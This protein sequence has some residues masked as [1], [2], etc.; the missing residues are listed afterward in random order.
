MTSK[1]ATVEPIAVN[2]AKSDCVKS[3]PKIVVTGSIS[4]AN[5][6]GMNANTAIQIKQ[7]VISLFI[8]SP[9]IFSTP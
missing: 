8:L 9:L 4:L 3:T 7:N 1:D 2:P 5:T 6:C